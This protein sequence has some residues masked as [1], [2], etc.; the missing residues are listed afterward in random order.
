MRV[1]MDKYGSIVRKL[2]G[3]HDAI[4]VDTQAAFDGI[5]AQ[6]HP[7][8]LAWDRIHP[9]HIGTMLIAKAFLDA[10]GFEW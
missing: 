6:L 7:M 10:I 8:S 3:K 5:L 9:N 4:F 1:A 2:A